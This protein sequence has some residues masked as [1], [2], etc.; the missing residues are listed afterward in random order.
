MIDVRCLEQL[1]VTDTVLYKN[2]G[3]KVVYKANSEDYGNV[4]IKVIRPNQNLQR[5]FRE[6]EI[7]ENLTDVTTAKIFQHGSFFCDEIEYLYI[8]ENFIDGQNLREY[9]ESVTQISIEEVC[10]FLN[11]M[12]K[13]IV[14]LEESKLVHRDIKPENIM[15][16]PTGEYILIDFGIARDLSRTSFTAT[17]SPRGPATLAYAPIE[18]IDNEKD[19]IDSRTD[20]YSLCLVAYEMISGT[21]PFL[22]GCT[23][24]LQL[25]RKID[26]GVFEELKDETYQELLD[27]IHTNMNRYRTRRV[28]NAKEAQKWFNDISSRLCKGVS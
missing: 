19:K 11:M 28:K 10:Y 15:R 22:V 17:A 2:A 27:F 20:L 1:N 14:K 18:Q 9:L 23:S 3:Q 26:K 12:L 7:V 21:N 24:D 5:I 8:I 13:I 16:T 6:I 4:V 25:L